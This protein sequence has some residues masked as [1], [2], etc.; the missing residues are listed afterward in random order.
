MDQFGR[1]IW[2]SITSSA[3][4]STVTGSSRPSAWAALRLITSSNLAG[5]TTGRSASFSPLRIGR[6]SR[7]HREID[8]R[9]LNLRAPVTLAEE[10]EVLHAILF[11]LDECSTSANFG[12]SSHPLACSTTQYANSGRKPA[13]LPASFTNLRHRRMIV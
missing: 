13:D 11:S 12:L 2:E 6:R 8:V 5:C 4:A 10:L 7:G 1:Q 3:S 9:D